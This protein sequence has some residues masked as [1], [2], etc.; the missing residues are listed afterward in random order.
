MVNCFLYLY[1]KSEIKTLKTKNVAHIK[2]QQIF[3]ATIDEKKT[4]CGLSNQ[5][6]DADTIARFIQRL[7]NKEYIKYCCKK[8]ESKIQNNPEYILNN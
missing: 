6:K 1:R 3:H 5:Y 8:C 2:N 7:Q 4:L